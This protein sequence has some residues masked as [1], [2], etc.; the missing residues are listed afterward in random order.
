MF[1][2][3]RNSSVPTIS[4]NQA[5]TYYFNGTFVTVEARNVS[6]ALTR[7]RAQKSARFANEAALTRVQV[8]EPVCLTHNCTVHDHRTSQAS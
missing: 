1:A 7:V 5:W 8:L 2:S 3:R 4:A 6:E